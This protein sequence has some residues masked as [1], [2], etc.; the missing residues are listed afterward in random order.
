MTAVIHRGHWQL[1]FTI[2]EAVIVNFLQFSIFHFFP[3]INCLPSLNLPPS[4][5]AIPWLCPTGDNSGQAERNN[6]GHHTPADHPSTA[7]V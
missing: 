4:N 7:G 3:F 1:P 2:V 5:A 6:V